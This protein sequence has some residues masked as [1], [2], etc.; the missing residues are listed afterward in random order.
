MKFITNVGANI[1]TL[2]QNSRLKFSNYVSHLLKSTPEKRYSIWNQHFINIYLW[3]NTILTIICSC[4]KMLLPNPRTKYRT[5]TFPT[6]CAFSTRFSTNYLRFTVFMLAV[7]GQTSSLLF[8]VGRLLSRC[9]Q[10]RKTIIWVDKWIKDNFIPLHL[11]TFSI[12]QDQIWE[13][14][15]ALKIIINKEH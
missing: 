10:L 13:G 1:W 7:C 15:L 12:L 2:A 3:Q 11:P 14:Q 4:S 5:C 9:A 8:H 6:H